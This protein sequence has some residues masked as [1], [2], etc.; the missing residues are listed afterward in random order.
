MLK[1]I[2]GLR[3]RTLAA[4]IIQYVGSCAKKRCG[5]FPEIFTVRSP[6]KQLSFIV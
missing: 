1:Q 6:I 5:H 2:R 3:H 4:S